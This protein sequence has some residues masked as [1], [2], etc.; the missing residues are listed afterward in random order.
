[1]DA[2]TVSYLQCSA[3]IMYS[4]VPSLNISTV[5]YANLWINGAYIS[6]QSR[7]ENTPSHQT[8]F[9]GDF[10]DNGE[11]ANAER[12]VYGK[13]STKYFQSQCFR[14]VCTPCFGANR[15]GSSSQGVSWWCVCDLLACLHG[16]YDAMRSARSVFLR[17]FLS[18]LSSALGSK[19]FF[20]FFQTNDGW[21]AW[22]ATTSEYEREARSVKVSRNDRP[23]G[24]GGG[25]GEGLCREHACIGVSTRK[26][27][28]SSYHTVRNAA[29]CRERDAR[30]FTTHDPNMGHNDAAA[31]S[32][33][34]LK[35][36]RV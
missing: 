17:F 25:G 6:G 28:R 34:P 33:R 16:R 19:T 23:H 14:C 3:D 11:S 8:I 13:V 22:K 9:Q 12:C 35:A 21:P 4:Y 1:M 26:C 2:W 29:C 30:K 32:S 24:Q 7:Q 5:T 10:L 36:D 27:S 18:D 15:L 31:G 20:F